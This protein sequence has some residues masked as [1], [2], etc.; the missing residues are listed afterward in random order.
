MAPIAWSLIETIEEIQGERFHLE[1]L[2]SFEAASAEAYR[3]L[4][5]WGDAAARDD[6]S[7]MFG[8]IWGA[9]RVL[10]RRLA[11]EVRRGEQLLELG[12]GLALPSLVAAR[13]GARVTA[14]DQHPD[15][16]ALLSRNLSKNGL[17]DRVRYL[18]LDWRLPNPLLPA[19][20]FDRVIASDVLYSRELPA[21]VASMFARF[22]RPGG[23]GWLADPGRAWLPEVV[24]AGRV[25][26]LQV[27][28]DVDRDDLGGEAFVVVF[29]RGAPAGPA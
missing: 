14:T 23:V 10:A 22:L 9:A 13:R 28:I 26:G 17:S 1:A 3:R 18:T 21:L 6:L 25:R 7:P 24:E 16:G 11:L 15:T 20:S 4:G 2:P 19:V 12:C 29:T 5:A 27:T 8:V